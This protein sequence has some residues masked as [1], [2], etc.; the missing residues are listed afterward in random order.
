[1][2]EARQQQTSWLLPPDSNM[3]WLYGKAA[4]EDPA[5]VLSD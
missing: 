5:E 1:M 2:A 3:V 4:E